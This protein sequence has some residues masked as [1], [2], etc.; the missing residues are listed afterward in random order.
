MSK[1]PPRTLNCA[2]SSTIGTRSNPIASRCDARSAG[3][4]RRIRGP[5]SVALPQLHPRRGQGARKLG[6]LE[7]R[8][9]GGDENP[10][11]ALPNPLEGL[12]SLSGDFRVGLGFAETFPW[13]VER[14]RLGFDERG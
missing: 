9:G 4:G 10:E 7:K 5:A 14:D 13:R 3:L 1:I 2:T 11:I 12:H 8:A 6:A